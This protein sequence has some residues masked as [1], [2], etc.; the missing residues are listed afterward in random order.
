MIFFRLVNDWFDE[1]ECDVLDVKGFCLIL[2]DEVLISLN[3]CFLY[4][5]INRGEKFFDGWWLI[6]VKFRFVLSVD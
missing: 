1:D 3:Y 6:G 5:M 2:C 4:I